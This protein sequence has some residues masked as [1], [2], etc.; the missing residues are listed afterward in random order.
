MEIFAA[1]D[2]KPFQS[3]LAKL[4]KTNTLF[5]YSNRDVYIDIANFSVFAENF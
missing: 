2:W 4:G 3:C 5:I 1:Y